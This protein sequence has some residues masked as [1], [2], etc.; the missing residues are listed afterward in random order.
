MADKT[1]RLTFGL[2]DG[3]EKAVAFTAPQG[4]TGKTA[5][6]YA[7]DGGYTGTEEEFAAKLATKVQGVFY[8]EGTGGTA[9]TWLGTHADITGYYDGL[10]VLY[11]VGIAGA[12]GG[13]TLNING[14]GAASVL[15]NAS[16]AVTTTYP[17]GTV[18]LLTYS[19]GS[20]LVADYDANTKNSAGT[21]NKTA[22]KL[23][24]VGGASQS[25]S[26]VTTYT[27]ANCYIGTDNRLY[28]GGA[29]VP[30]VAEITA[31][32]EAQLGVIE[33]GAY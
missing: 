27:N 8:I 16:T 28:S 1:Y 14:L 12:S 15:R 29:L 31:L 23:Y 33:N 13:T 2:S 6:E 7:V 25:S 21:S 32:I 18:L 19:G 4:E 26:G 5:Y 24:L 20:W 11:K 10:A 30:N 3:S 17:V 22:A 9:G